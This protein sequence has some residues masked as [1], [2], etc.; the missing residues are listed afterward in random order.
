MWVTF[1]LNTSFSCC[2]K[3]GF[4][5]HSENAGCASHVYFLLIKNVYD[6]SVFNVFYLIFTDYVE[7][8]SEILFLYCWQLLWYIDISVCELY[9]QQSDAGLMLSFFIFKVVDNHV[10]R[11]IP[12]EEFHPPRTSVRNPKSKRRLGCL[13]VG[14][15]SADP[16]NV[17]T[18]YKF[19][20][21][22]LIYF[23]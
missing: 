14:A 10:I 7:S 15:E 2:S 9:V 22:K 13:L 1:F 21:Y 8:T 23:I 16:Q 20:V 12:P 11:Y 17:C 3:F 18:C 19:V 5:T 6:C 4:F